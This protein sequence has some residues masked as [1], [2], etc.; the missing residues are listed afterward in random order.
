MPKEN[1]TLYGLISK[2]DEIIYKNDIISE[3]KNEIKNLE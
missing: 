2:K 3:L 1:Q